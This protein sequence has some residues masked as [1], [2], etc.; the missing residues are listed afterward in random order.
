MDAFVTTGW[1]MREVSTTFNNIQQLWI[2][3]LKIN[4]GAPILD[5][6]L[7][8][9]YWLYLSVVDDTLSGGCFYG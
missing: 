4:M 8:F 1:G 7:I 5:N 9:Q 6:G 2:F 3:G